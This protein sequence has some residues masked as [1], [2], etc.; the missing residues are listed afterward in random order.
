MT[1]ATALGNSAT[2]SGINQRWSDSHLGR[3]RSFWR[4]YSRNRL[5]VAALAIVGG[6]ILVAVFAPVLSPRPPL[7]LGAKSF[8]SPSR[9]YLL[10]TDDLGRDTLSGLI[11]GARISL[12]VGLLASTIS[13][14]LGLLFGSLAGYFGGRLDAVVMR[15]TE[16]FLVTPQ[17]FIILAIVALVG[18]SIWNIIA[19]I[20]LF[21]WPGTARIVRAETLS[22]RERDF[23][24]AA[25]AIGTSNA[26]IIRRHIVPN[27]LPSVIVVAS[28]AVGRAI[29][30]EAG[31]SFLGLGDPRLVS[32]GKMLNNAQEF[33]GRTLRLAIFPGL[34]I[35][36]SVLSI[37]L[38][39]DGINEALNPQ[40]RD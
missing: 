17:F 3:L 14:V 40:L 1:S 36:I 6:V 5:S 31:L 2:G 10:G 28:L 21:S 22:W 27:V 8:A 26:Y 20:G 4:A 29:L 16:F 34:A 15:V 11:Y 30:L 12:I 13:T 38:V 39:G 24:T 19:V 23:V 9:E 32:W 35:F 33:L 7:Q 18:P 25:R 37:N